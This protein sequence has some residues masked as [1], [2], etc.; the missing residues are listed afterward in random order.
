MPDSAPGVDDHPHDLP[1]ELA[2]LETRVATLEARF[3]AFFAEPGDDDDAPRGLTDPS[4]TDLTQPSRQD[5]LQSPWVPGEP[6]P[7]EPGQ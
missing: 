2:A 6:P 4:R 1:A 5:L 3:D 7:A